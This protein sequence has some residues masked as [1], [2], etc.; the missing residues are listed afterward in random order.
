MAQLVGLIVSED[1]TFSK[2]VGRLLRAG[3]I[4][5]SVIEDRAGRDGPPPDLIIVDARGD[6]S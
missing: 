2:D 6:G 5:I 1:N 3:A 4:S